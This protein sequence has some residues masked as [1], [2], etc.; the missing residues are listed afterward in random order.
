MFLG[1]RGMRQ[2][3]ETRFLLISYDINAVMKFIINE[4]MI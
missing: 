4:V 1:S 3:E 2:G